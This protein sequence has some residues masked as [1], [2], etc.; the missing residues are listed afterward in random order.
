MQT[1]W[2]S[3]DVELSD[4]TMHY[5]RTGGSKPA[6]VLAHGFSD[7]GMCWLPVAQDLS[8]S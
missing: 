2:Q 8:A 1:N 5:T 6:V 3:G 4:M 7:N